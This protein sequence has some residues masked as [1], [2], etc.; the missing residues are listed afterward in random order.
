[1]KSDIFIESLRLVR[2]SLAESFSLVDEGRFY[3]GT[4]HPIINIP[5]L[6][7]SYLENWIYVFT[8]KNQDDFVQFSNN[9]FSMYF[10]FIIRVYYQFSSF[11]ILSY[12]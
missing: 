2:H 4:T 7:I 10:K 5:L 1:M 9:I 12:Y 11:F 6:C 3:C 8:K